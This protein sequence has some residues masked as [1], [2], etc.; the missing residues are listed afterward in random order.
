MLN[1]RGKSV[2]K[3]VINQ[4]YVPQ[5]YL[6]RFCSDGKHFD[7]WN[8]RNDAVIP[9]QQVRNFAAKRYFYDADNTV[10][11]SAL[12]EMEVYYGTSFSPFLEENDQFV[13]KGLSRAEADIANTLKQIDKDHN[14]LYEDDVRI[15]LIIFLHDLAFRTEA[16][17]N[18]IDNI[19]NQLRSHLLRLGIDSA[20]AKELHTGQETQLYQLL[21]ISPLLKTA[22]K[23]ETRYLWY[24]GTVGGT[25]KLIISD[26]PAQGIWLGF[27][28]ICFPI[29]G[30]QAIIFKVKNQ[31]APII[32]SDMPVQNEITLSDRS[33][34][35]Y[36][37]IQSSYANRFIF[38]DKESLQCC[39]WLWKFHEVTSSKRNLSL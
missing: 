12:S 28:D 33:V 35:K 27:N 4:H 31:N 17:R 39:R 1:K 36:N 13:E 15:K 22:E 11:K 34:L 18:Q 20:Q 2:G 8:I 23:L 24:F 21:G 29:S 14:R 25:Q 38:G 5:M 30:E 19:S 16:Y 3:K 37:I 26:N 10:L 7:V 6:S 32:S 9:H